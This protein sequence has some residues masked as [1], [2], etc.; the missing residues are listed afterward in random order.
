MKVRHN[1]SNRRI[2]KKKSDLLRQYGFYTL[3]ASYGVLGVYW[4]NKWM[5]PP[6]Y[7]SEEE[8]ESKYKMYVK[9]LL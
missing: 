3:L 6:E 7:Q 5:H 1:L 2:L 4:F 8:K 9:I